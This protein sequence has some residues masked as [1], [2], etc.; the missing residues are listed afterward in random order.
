M[1][2][3]STAFLMLAAGHDNKPTWK[4]LLLIGCT[5]IPI[6]VV[7]IFSSIAGFVFDC[8]SI[9]V[10][11]A[12]ISKKWWTGFVGLAL[13]VAFQAISM[14]IR[15]IDFGHTFDD[16][17]I[18]SLVFSIDYYI[19]IA[20]CVQVRTIRLYIFVDNC[21]LVFTRQAYRG[22]IPICGVCVSALQISENVSPPQHLL[23]RILVCF[24]VLVVHSCGSP[25]EIQRAIWCSCRDDFMLYIVQ[26]PR[27]C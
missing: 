7:K 27:L 16:N 24:V 22:G 25:A 20:L 2:I 19:M 17:T 18:L 14:F 1:S 23:V 21:V 13:N 6:W 9:I 5:I 11:P 12:I 4:H 8:V 10:I 15:G 3:T 26:N